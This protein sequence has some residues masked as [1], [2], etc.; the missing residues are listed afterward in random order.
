[1]FDIIFDFVFYTFTAIGTHTTTLGHRQSHKK[2]TRH[3][4]KHHPNNTKKTYTHTTYPAHNHHTYN[5][6]Q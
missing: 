2:Y 6:I 3:T 5:T 1:M 4:H